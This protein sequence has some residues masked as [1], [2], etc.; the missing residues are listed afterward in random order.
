MSTQLRSVGSSSSFVAMALAATAMAARSQSEVARVTLEVPAAATFNLRCTIP[1][2][3]GTWSPSG[4]LPLKVVQPGG[5]VIANTQMQAVTMAPGSG[6]V[7][8]A[9]VIATITRPAS[10]LPGQLQQVSIVQ[11]PSGTPPTCVPGVAALRNGPTGLPNSVNGLL[12][13]NLNIVVVARDPLGNEYYGLPLRG[14]D[15]IECNRFGPYKATMRFFETMLPVAAVVPSNHYPHLFGL[16]S[17]VST[18]AQEEALSLD[19]RLTNGADGSDGIPNNIDDVLGKVYFESIDLLIKN[20][21]NKWRAQMQFLDPSGIPANYTPTTRTFR[22]TSYLV[23]PLVKALPAVAGVTPCHMMPAKG[24]MHRRLM[25]TPL[26]K[27]AHGRNLLNGEGLGFATMGTSSGGGAPLWSWQNAA[28]ANYFPQLAKLPDLSFTNAGYGGLSTLR[29]TLSARFTQLRDAVANNTALPI[30]GSP[31]LLGWARPSGVT[32][33]YGHGGGGIA[34]IY[35]ELE[36]A[37]GTLHGF[38]GLQLRHRLRTERQFNVMW[39]RNGAPSYQDKWLFPG[40]GP[41]GPTGQP[42]ASL[43]SFYMDDGPCDARFTPAQVPAW[44]QNQAVVS[45]SRKPVYD[46]D[47]FCS[48]GPTA[49]NDDNLNAY[50]PD[51]ASHLIRSLGEPMAIAW[52]GNDPLAKDDVMAQA[53]MGRMTFTEY[54]NPHFNHSSSLYSMTQTVI[55]N[56]SCGVHIGRAQA[57][58]LAAAAAANTFRTP[59]LQVRNREWLRRAIAMCGMAT[60]DVVDQAFLNSSGM[61]Y[62]YGIL[63]ATEDSV[64]GFPAG[65]RARQSWEEMLLQNALRGVQW[66]GLPRTDSAQTTLV[67]V[68]VKDHLAV[69]SPTHWNE[70]GHAPWGKVPVSFATSPCAFFNCDPSF[71]CSL[72]GSNPLPLSPIGD[73]AKH[74]LGSSLAAGYLLT[75]DV[76]FLQRAWDWLSGGAPPCTSNCGPAIRAQIEATMNPAD[77][78]ATSG[79]ANTAHLL[80]LVQ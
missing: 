52:L 63:G 31:F 14:A 24:Q 69:L 60:A 57:W 22:G 23:F 65:T 29:S 49:Y 76:L 67:R 72:V 77:G 33:G 11:Q 66:S 71:L 68:A 51:W 80:A 37:A 6:D 47:A 15:G 44:A 50:M 9:E 35:G 5:A 4:T 36:V 39:D 55:A 59:T 74:Y 21:A 62:T 17:Y 73:E 78:N 27:V 3:P 26:T 34:T 10:W 46:G 25:I 70:A 43:L 18:E 2:P 79:N 13:N 75:S 28:T 12:N 64:F 54:P 32:N 45:G 58:I 7:R 41:L 1:L 20:D 56:P 40:A 19:L 48:S 53:E 30:G 16:H 38:L 42:S 8:V 61:A